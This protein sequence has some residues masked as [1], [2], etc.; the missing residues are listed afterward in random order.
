M[1]LSFLVIAALMPVMIL[2]TGETDHSSDF[3]RRSGEAKELLTDAMLLVSELQEGKNAAGKNEIT[4]GLKKQAEKL[5]S[6]TNEFTSKMEQLPKDEKKEAMKGLKKALSNFK[7]PLQQFIKK[8]QKQ[9]TE[10]DNKSAPDDHDSCPAPNVLNSM[11]KEKTDKAKQEM[12]EL[13]T[14]VAR[15]KR[16]SSRKLKIKRALSYTIGLPVHFVFGILCLVNIPIGKIGFL[17]PEWANLL[18]FPLVL[19]LVSTVIMLVSY[20]IEWFVIP[21]EDM[22]TFEAE[23]KKYIAYIMNLKIKSA[24]LGVE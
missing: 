23:F 21:K 15:R 14:S 17:L 5:E 3:K 9:L 18:L 1:M 19:N 6:V 13:K 4:N 16:G 12:H 7:K 24:Y 10:S 2:S 8:V 20:V 11:L 22:D